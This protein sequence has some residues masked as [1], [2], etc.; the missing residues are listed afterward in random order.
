MVSRFKVLSEFCLVKRRQRFPCSEAE[1]KIEKIKG[2][3][4]YVFHK[5]GAS[6]QDGQGCVKDFVVSIRSEKA[7]GATQ[8]PTKTKM[9]CD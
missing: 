2:V 9:P 8:P 5:L 3:K 6:L 1:I 7:F 4:G